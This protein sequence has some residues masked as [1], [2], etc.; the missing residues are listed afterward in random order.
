MS[1]NMT[2]ERRL[3]G[4]DVGDWSILLFGLTLVGLMVLLV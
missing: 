4:F 3:L 2:T 1:E